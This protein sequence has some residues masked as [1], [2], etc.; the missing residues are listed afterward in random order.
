MRQA[1]KKIYPLLNTIH[2]NTTHYGKC[3]APKIWLN[4]SK[5]K[6]KIREKKHAEVLNETPR[7]NEI[8]PK[9]KKHQNFN[10]A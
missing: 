3:D 4:G 10:I 5:R 8:R 1:T 7:Q 2:P 9:I 6:K